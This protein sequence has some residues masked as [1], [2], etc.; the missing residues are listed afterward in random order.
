[1]TLEK[2]LRMTVPAKDKDG[3]DIKITPDF[4]VAVQNLECEVDGKKGVHVI[5]HAQNHNSD[6]VDLLVC[7]NQT[8]KFY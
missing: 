5:V 6:T 3:N 4:R 2:L 8:W 7:G 1:M